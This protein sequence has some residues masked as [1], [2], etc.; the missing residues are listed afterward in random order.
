MFLH[1][2]FCP[3]NRRRVAITF[4]YRVSGPDFVIVLRFLVPLCDAID[5]VVKKLAEIG[6]MHVRWARLPVYTTYRT[7]PLNSQ[8]LVKF[9]IHSRLPSRLPQPSLSFFI[10]NPSGAELRTAIFHRF[11]ICDHSSFFW[12]SSLPSFIPLHQQTKFKMPTPHN[13]PTLAITIWTHQLLVPPALGFF[14]RTLMVLRR[15]G[16]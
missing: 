1:R 7:F 16:R 9:S 13:L 15:S 3:S 11:S 12:R 2:F 6:P 4:H 14:G 8:S 10:F 5:S